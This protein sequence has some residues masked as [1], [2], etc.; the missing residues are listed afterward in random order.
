MADI[1][2]NLTKSILTTNTKSPSTFKFLGCWFIFNNKQSEQIRLIQDETF[3]LNFIASTKRITDK[4]IAYVINTVII[5]ILEYRIY[6]IVFSCSICNNILS[7]YFTIAKHKSHLAKSISNST[8]LN[9][10]LYNI[11]NIWDIQL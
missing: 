4:Q 1:Q 3:Q 6:N 11:Q 2:I 8:I 7:K 9:L 10:Y 5:S